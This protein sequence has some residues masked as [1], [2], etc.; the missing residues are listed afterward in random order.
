M[1]KKVVS[2]GTEGSDGLFTY[3]GV[4]VKGYESGFTYL[5]NNYTSLVEAV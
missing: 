5:N 3:Q 1:V 2:Q 4:V